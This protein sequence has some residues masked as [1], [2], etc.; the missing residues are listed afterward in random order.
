MGSACLTSRGPGP[1]QSE[2]QATARTVER[3]HL[4][5]P[6]HTRV[7]EV[8]EVLGPLNWSATTRQHPQPDT[9]KAVSIWTLIEQ[10]LHGILTSGVTGEQTC[11]GQASA[12]R[13]VFGSAEAQRLAVGADRILDAID[14][15]QRIRVH[16]LATATSSLSIQEHHSVAWSTPAEQRLRIEVNP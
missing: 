14:L 10:L 12:K 3:S 4:I 9:A 15:E 7:L 1:R 2:G 6:N 11:L 13:P 5:G 16:A 8:L